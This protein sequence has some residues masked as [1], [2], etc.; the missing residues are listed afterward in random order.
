MALAPKGRSSN[1]PA[2]TVEGSGTAPIVKTYGESIVPNMSV[3]VVYWPGMKF[4][5]GMAA[6]RSPDQERT[7]P[8]KYLVSPSLGAKPK[9]AS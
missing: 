6:T 9:F 8:G 7:V 5:K 3:V 1:A 4:E 2:T